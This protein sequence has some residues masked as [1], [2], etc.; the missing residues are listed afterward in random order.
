MTYTKRDLIIIT[1]ILQGDLFTVGLADI[2]QL[3]THGY[4][5]LVKRLTLKKFMDVLTIPL[6]ISQKDN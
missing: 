2:K 4:L 1:G 5:T 6:I 3:F